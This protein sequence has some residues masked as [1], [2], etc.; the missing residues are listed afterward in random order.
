MQM[1]LHETL[2][3]SA[4][5]D[6][7]RALRPVDLAAGQVL[8]HQG[9]PGDDIFLVLSGR[10]AIEV[11]HADGT[12]TRVDEVGPGN[13][14]GEMALLTGQPRTATIRA[15]DAARL[16]CLSRKDFDRLSADHADALKPFLQ[17]VLP[18]MRSTQLV[19]LLTELFGRM[20]PTVL[21]EI[22]SKLDWVRLR[23]GA[24]LFREGDVS[25]HVYL[26]VNGRL[27]VV[28]TEPD[29]RERVLEEVGRGSAVGE[30]ALLTGEP[31]AATVFAVRDTYLLAPVQERLRRTPRSLPA[32]D[33]AG[34]ARR[35]LAAAACRAAGAEPR[36]PAHDVRA[37]SGEPRRAARRVRAPLERDAARLQRH[38][39]AHLARR[40][41]HPRQAGDRADR[42]RHD[43]ARIDGGLAR[44]AGTR[45]RLARAAGRSGLDRV[46]PALRDAGRPGA[47]R[48]PG[49]RRQRARRDRAR[50]RAARPQGADRTGA[51][52]CRRRRA[53]HRHARLARRP[54][55]SP[56]T[57]TCASATTAT[58]AGWRA[59]SAIAPRDSC[60]AA[61]ARAASRTS[62]CCARSTKRASKWTWSA[63]RAS[64]R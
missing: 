15:T 34:G 28:A 25:D 50:L 29:G 2:G 8:M 41:P 43:R 59:A 9:D 37:D 36:E 44:R 30:V 60:S 45:S 33:D 6:L 42:R 56:P 51:A 53:A 57:T 21:A 12:S 3:A 18:R 26:V 47:A 7:R 58:C 39:L 40:R 55:R 14:V 49:R 11:E 31:R 46:D 1:H 17:E 61:A 4:Y 13:V 38:A 5:A 62:G 24:V 10:L 16:A 52:P 32:R 64:A 23:S 19:Q 20:D 22:E 27:R 63:A 35:G 54:R 48:G